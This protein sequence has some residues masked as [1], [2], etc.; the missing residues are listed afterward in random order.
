MIFPAI[1]IAPHSDFYYI[2]GAEALSSRTKA[3]NA[4]L[5]WWLWTCYNTD[6]DKINQA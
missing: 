5:T 3:Y 4:L 2:D 1:V 6:F